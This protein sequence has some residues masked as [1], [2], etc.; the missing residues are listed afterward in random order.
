MRQLTSSSEA[1]VRHHCAYCG[2]VREDILVGLVGMSAKPHHVQIVWEAVLLESL[3]G[4]R[5]AAWEWSRCQ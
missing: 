4:P 1:V 5:Q 2:N 3:D